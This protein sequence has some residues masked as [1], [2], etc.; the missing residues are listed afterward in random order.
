MSV[1][2]FLAHFVR[3]QNQF[4]KQFGNWVAWTSLTLVGITA[5]V[6]ILRYGFQTGSIALQESIMYNHAILFM[7]G[8]A[9]TYVHDQHVRVD[10]FYT[11][12]DSRRKAWVNLLGTLL[13]TLPVMT[14]II[15]SGW[16]YVATSWQIKEASAEAGGIEYLYVLKTL[17]IIMAV[18][19]IF[20]ALSVMSNAYL[21]LFNPPPEEDD[22]P[23]IDS[24]GKV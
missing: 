15:I 3:H 18:L 22:M 13:F 21:T 5:T 11:R 19:L 2:H 8:I 24:R 10:V 16:D 14:F 17:I 23:A 7:L 12:F 4:Q 9:Y 20:Q 1:H 6:V